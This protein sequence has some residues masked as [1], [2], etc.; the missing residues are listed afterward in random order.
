MH[1]VD[2][3]TE[4]ADLVKSEPRLRLTGG[5]TKPATSHD[6]NVSVANL[7]GVLKY[8]PGEFTF[9]ALAGTRVEEVE[10][11]LADKNQFLPFDPPLAAAGA[12][13]GGTV[14]SGLSGSGRYRFGGVR[15]FLLGAKI[16]IGDGTTV[17][18][19]SQVVKNAAGFDF[20]KLM[21][22]G[23]GCYGLLTELTF[24][25][26]PK[27]QYSATVMFEPDGL[28]DSLRILRELAGSQQDFACLD[29]DS[30][31]RILARICGFRSAV[32][33]RA[34]KAI[35]SVSVPGRILSHEEEAACWS[36]SREF[37]WLPNGFQLVKLA[38]TPN[39]IKELSVRIG[40]LPRR[41]SVGGNVA[42]V[43]WPGDRDSAE[44]GHVLRELSCAGVFVTGQPQSP[45]LGIVQDNPF[46]QRIRA[47]IDPHG[48]FSL[49]QSLQSGTQDVA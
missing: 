18:T 24:K 33:S 1:I 15:D 39:R 25:V 32:P 20:P 46:A 7:S 49:R 3:I 14:A 36:E 30:Q 11:L 4:L 26:F 5:G 19:G 34:E 29:L 9:S 6:A 38:M 43:G 45:Y 28:D 40:E 42:W 17:T 16:I 13:L 35:R 23:L 2:D 8:D 48:K 37:G 12:T 10:T 27:P 47:A 31:D 44:L 22:G 41:F 21:V